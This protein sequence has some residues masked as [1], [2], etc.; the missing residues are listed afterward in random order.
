V[1]YKKFSLFVVISLLTIVGLIGCSS[2]SSSEGEGEK[3]TFKIGHIRPDGTGTDEDVKWFA[4]KIAE[5]TDSNVEFE[6]YPASQLGD[7]TVVQERVSMGDIEMQLAPVGPSLN[8]NMGLTY[9]PFLVTNW[10]DA[11][12]YYGPDSEIA[13]M[14]DEMLQEQ[15]I[16][17][18]ATYPKY[19]GGIALKEKPENPA[20][21]SKK[22]I[23]VRVPATKAFELA[24]KGLGYTP[25]PLPFAE[26][27]TS[28][29]TGIVDGVV[30]SGAEGYYADFR[31]LTKYYLPINTHFEMWYLYISNDTWEKLSAEEQEIFQTTAK[32]LAAARFEAAPAET[33]DFEQ[34]LQDSGIEII[35]YTDEELDNIAKEIR[36]NIWPEL[37][38]EYGKELFERVTKGIDY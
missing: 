20:D 25:T 35:E 17:L 26:A 29:Q 34:K 10:E 4:E 14:V 16:K 11:F 1:N 24:A 8:P 37:E 5:K 22:D 7:Y 15:N 2:S 18:L 32:E 23:K 27:F 28:M 33:A 21:L 12:K 6:V 19:F 13:K 9:T 30:G 3:K 31:D 38:K 36:K